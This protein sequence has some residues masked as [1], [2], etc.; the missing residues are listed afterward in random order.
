M[1]EEVAGI[2]LVREMFRIADGE[3]LGY[4]DPHLRGH[5]FEFRINAEDGGRGFLPAPGTAAPRCGG[6][7]GAGGPARR[8]CRGRDDGRPSRSTRWSRS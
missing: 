3:T 6:P 5:S 2:D 1:T 4:G 8:R 7:V